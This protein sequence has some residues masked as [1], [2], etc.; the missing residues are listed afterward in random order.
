VSDPRIVY[1]PRPDVTPEGELNALATV[2]RFILDCHAEKKATRP[3]RPDS[4]KGGSK[5]DSSATKNSTS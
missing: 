1:A 5:N 4:A 3:G 2:Y